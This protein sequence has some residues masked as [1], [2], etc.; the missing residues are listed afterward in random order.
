MPYSKKQNNEAFKNLDE[1][2]Q[3]SIELG[4]DGNLT[5]EFY[6]KLK[7]VKKVRKS[8]KIQLILLITLFILILYKFTEFVSN[9]QI[10][11][12]SENI[13]EPIIELGVILIL[14]IILYAIYK[15]LCIWIEISNIKQQRFKEYYEKINK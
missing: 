3:K 1:M 11:C 14:F 7:T 9:T 5:P 8:L 10:S 13:E 6:I 15:N 2:H 4:F 12:V